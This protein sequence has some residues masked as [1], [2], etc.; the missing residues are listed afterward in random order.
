MSE[1]E[2]DSISLRK[3]ELSEPEYYSDINPKLYSQRKPFIW[4][5]QM[6]DRSPLGLNAL[7]AHRF[8]RMLAPLI[9]KSVGE[10]F[11]CW[12]YVEWSFGYNLSIGNNVVI[13]RHVLLDDRDLERYAEIGETLPRGNRVIAGRW[14]AAPQTPN[15][16]SIEEGFAR[17]LGVRVGSKVTLDVQGVPVDF[18]V[19]ALDHLSHKADINKRCFHLVD[20][21]GYRVGDVLDI[22][23]KK[24]APAFQVA[25]QVGLAGG[26]WFVANWT[27]GAG[28]V[29]GFLLWLLVLG[30]VAIFDDHV[31]ADRFVWG[32][33][34][35]TVGYFISRGLAKATRVLE[36]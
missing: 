10:N 23:R 17:N 29:A 4:L 21:V 25:L 27:L 31:S 34:W 5:W 33:T 1:S 15:G 2:A 11:K 26:W 18:V 14:P 24:T 13:H 8:R 19:N 32:A 6:F 12:Q 7:F 28:M 20:P 35:I 30:L 36:Q 16:V 22:F 9:F 3:I